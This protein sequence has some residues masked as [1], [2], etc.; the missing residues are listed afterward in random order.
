MKSLPIASLALVLALSGCSSS[1]SIEEET[2]S[3]QQEIELKVKLIEYELCLRTQE[4]YWKNL[5]EY[6]NPQTVE[7][8]A[9]ENCANKRP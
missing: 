6:L 9:L 4:E 5:N 1:P 8:L 3:E 2:E 7:G